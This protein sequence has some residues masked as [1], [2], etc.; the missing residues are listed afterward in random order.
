MWLHLCYVVFDRKKE[1]RKKNN[2]YEKNVWLMSINEIQ[3]KTNKYTTNL[4]FYFVV[5]MVVRIAIMNYFYFCTNLLTLPLINSYVQVFIYHWK[6]MFS[7]N[8]IK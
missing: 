7:Q 3:F 1:S 8:N 6:Y 5:F 4:A 2:I